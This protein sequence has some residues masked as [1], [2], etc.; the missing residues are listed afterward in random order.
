MLNRTSC[1]LSFLCDKNFGVPNNLP[2]LS[3][4]TTRRSSHGTISCYLLLVSPKSIVT[5]QLREKVDSLVELWK[6]MDSPEEERRSFGKLKYILGSPAEEIN[7]KGVLS[8]EIIK[9]VCKSDNPLCFHY[10]HVDS[11]FNI[12]I[13]CFDRQMLK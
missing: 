7:Y 3:S 10:N 4:L 9:Q 5:M 12:H 2:Q 11:R 6:I 13:W 1:F 8:E